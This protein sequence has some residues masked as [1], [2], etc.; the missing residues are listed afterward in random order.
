M[1]ELPDEIRLGEPAEHDDGR[2][3][4]ATAMRI[5]RDALDA[6]KAPETADVHIELE[7]TQHRKL[8]RILERRADDPDVEIVFDVPM[9]GL[10]PDPMRPAL[11]ACS[12]F[13][14]AMAG[15]S[16]VSLDLD[17]AD[18]DPTAY[19]AAARALLA[20][21]HRTI[22][23]D[24]TSLNGMI[25]GPSAKPAAPVFPNQSTLGTMIGAL[26]D[27]TWTAWTDPDLNAPAFTDAGLQA[28]LKLYH[29]VRA[30][31]GSPAAR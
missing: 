29:D 13:L 20:E 26:I 16:A 28:A 1:I 30:A 18:L 4:R 8:R 21:L 17:P 10:P 14:N 19:W 9:D 25:Q 23:G 7:R 6:L 5:S 3:I 27:L 2:E 15:T 12:S 31:V 24:T 11:N 22:H